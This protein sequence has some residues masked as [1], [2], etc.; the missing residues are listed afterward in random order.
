M[1]YHYAILLH[2]VNATCRRPVG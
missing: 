1:K 2:T